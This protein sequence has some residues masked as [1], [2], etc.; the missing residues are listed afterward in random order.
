MADDMQLAI[1]VAILAAF[2]FVGCLATRPKRRHNT[3][4]AK[5]S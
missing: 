4:S 5:H 1:F 2:V 3:G